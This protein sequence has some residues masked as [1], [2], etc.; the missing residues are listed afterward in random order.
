MWIKTIKATT[1][2]A[3]CT[4]KSTENMQFTRNK[5]REKEQNLMLHQQLNSLLGQRNTI[6]ARTFT[7][8]MNKQSHSKHAIS[9]E[10]RGNN[11]LQN[12]TR[13]NRIAYR[14]GR[15][16]HDGGR[17]RKRRRRR[18]GGAMVDRRDGG[19]EVRRQRKVA[20]DVIESTDQ[21]LGRLNWFFPRI[22]D[23]AAALCYLLTH[24]G[25]NLYVY[26]PSFDFNLLIFFLYY[27]FFFPQSLLCPTP[28]RERER[29][30]TKM[31][32]AREIW[33]IWL[34]ALLYLHNYPLSLIL[35]GLYLRPIY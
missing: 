1:F 20:R 7:N 4:N 23:D 3:Q 5:I 9:Q 18:G 16:R 15:R 14:R 29:L 22:D 8:L 33:K 30:E 10:E 6:K 26:Y 31:R 21:R 25:G 34:N 17:E 32:P 27:L 28:T 13:T 12:L 19:E 2:R 35:N 11:K 24:H